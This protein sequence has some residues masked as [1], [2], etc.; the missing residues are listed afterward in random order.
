MRNR[1]NREVKLRNHRNETMPDLLSYVRWSD[2]AR[3]AYRLK[4][5]WRENSRSETA[6]HVGATFVSV[7]LFEAAIGFLG[8]LGVQTPGSVSMRYGIYAG[9]MAASM[10]K[11]ASEVVTLLIGHRRWENAGLRI[12]ARRSRRSGDPSWQVIAHLLRMSCGEHLPEDGRAQ[13]A[14]PRTQGPHSPKEQKTAAKLL[15]RMS[16]LPLRQL[17]EASQK[18]VGR[19]EKCWRCGA[20]GI[21]T[22][23][24]DIQAYAELTE[25]QQRLITALQSRWGNDWGSMSV[26]V[27]NRLGWDD[28]VLFPRYSRA[29][30]YPVNHHQATTIERLAET[31][32]SSDTDLLIEA[33]T[34]LS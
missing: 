17:S 11:G 33:G 10:Q 24:R 15:G 12:A 16:H 7:L 6:L 25:P 2:R 20:A 30:T 1:R 22:R 23:I 32:D 18:L 26:P 3:R 5:D 29:I 8:T 13:W 14:L 4:S 21:R 31:W 27:W 9:M 19:N 34:A 28:I